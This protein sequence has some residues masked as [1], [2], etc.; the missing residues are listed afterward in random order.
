MNIQRIKGREEGKREMKGISTRNTCKNG[1]EN[2]LMK[3]RSEVNSDV[4]IT[5]EEKV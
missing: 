5:D 4:S 1:R 2:S 3:I